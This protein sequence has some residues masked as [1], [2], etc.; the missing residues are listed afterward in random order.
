MERLEWQV[1]N[2]IRSVEQLERVINLTPDERAA[3]IQ[4][5]ANL[6]IAITSL[7]SVAA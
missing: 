4:R 2:R 6:P 7:L 5:T 1:R 3:V